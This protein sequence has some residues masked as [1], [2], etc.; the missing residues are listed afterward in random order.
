MLT[1]TNHKSQITNHESRIPNPTVYL[2]L[3]FKLLNRRFKDLGFE[4]WFAYVLLLVTLAVAVHQSFERFSFA[5]Y[6]FVSLVMML[7]LNLGESK[8]TDFLKTCFT[9]FKF[10]QIRLIENFLLALPCLIEFIIYQQWIA[11]ALTF[12]STIALA[13]VNI[14]IASQKT[15]PTPYSKQPFEFAV[16][17]RSTI[18]VFIAIY[19]LMG[20]ALFVNNFNLGMFSIGAVFVICMGF[21]TQPE[22]EFYVWIH[23]HS[24]HDF[25][26][27]KVIIAVLQVSVLSLPLAILLACCY[28]SLIEY[29]GL[30][31]FTA[32]AFMIAIVLAKY[33]AYPNEIQLVQ[34][35]FL[36]LSLLLPFLLLL[37]IPFF[38]NQAKQRLTPY[39]K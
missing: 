32:Y 30:L 7:Q 26:R 36:G 31:L 4:P 2:Q 10:R 6:V 35:F 25:L 20:I 29:I 18:V 34:V 22:N 5:P 15:I 11:L 27:Q 38:Y 28:P 39:L 21:Y 8:R 9:T 19:C 14:K 13:L 3:Q 33:A 16:G 1:N 37:F 12:T 24:A 23:H 17:F